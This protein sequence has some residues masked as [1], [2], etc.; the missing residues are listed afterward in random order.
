[1]RFVTPPITTFISFAVHAC[2]NL[3]P[4]E[5]WF[6]FKVKKNFQTLANDRR[7]TVKTQGLTVITQA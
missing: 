4:R 7:A 3:A 5:G 6:L 1:M 2:Q